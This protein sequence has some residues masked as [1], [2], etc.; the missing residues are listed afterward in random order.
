MKNLIRRFLTLK[1]RTGRFEFLNAAQSAGVG[2]RPMRIT[3]SSP[4]GVLIAGLLFYLMQAL[5]STDRTWT[6]DVD[7]PPFAVLEEVKIQPDPPKPV[8]PEPPPPPEIAATDLRTPPIVPGPVDV[9]PASPV[10]GPGFGPAIFF[11]LPTAVPLKRPDGG[12]TR[13]FTAVTGYPVEAARRGIEGW[14][15]V[16]ISVDEAGSV[17]A[18]QVVDEHPRGVFRQHALRAVRLWKFTPRYVDGKPTPSGIRQT[19]RYEI[20]D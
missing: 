15:E 18:I 6:D 9:V 12:P 11:G 1:Q 7:L 4:F 14:V 2:K 3:L 17:A 10:L 19:I 20:V 16:K 5:A 13:K 8:K